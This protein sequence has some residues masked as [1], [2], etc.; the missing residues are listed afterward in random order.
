MASGRNV[1]E[2]KLFGLADFTVEKIAAFDFVVQ[3]AYTRGPFKV[4]NF[5]LDVAIVNS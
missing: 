2:P 5:N 3:N 4:R 1:S